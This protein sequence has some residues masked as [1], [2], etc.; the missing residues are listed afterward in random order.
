MNNR[1][2]LAEESTL[3]GLLLDQKDHDEV[4]EILK[5]EDFSIPENRALY[6]EITDLSKKN[7]L[8]DVI[9]V[10]EKRGISL[11]R[12]ANLVIN[13]P[14]AANVITYATFVKKASNK[15]S[16][17]KQLELAQRQLLQDPDKSA[18]EIIE[19]FSLAV[20]P[21]AKPIN[22]NI[23]PFI[24]VQDMKIKTTQW[25]IDSFLEK[26]S[27]VSIFGPPEGCKSLV[28]MD[29]GLCI[30]TGK[31]WNKFKTSQGTVFFIAGEGTNGLSK[32]KEAWVKGNDCS[33]DQL[34]N[35][36]FLSK[37]AADFCSKESV[38]NVA[39]SIENTCK[40][41]GTPP[42]LIII[43]TLARNFGSGNEN[44]TEDM[45]KF[46]EHI[47]TYL[48]KP[49]KTTVLII[50][51]SGHGSHDRGRGSSALKAGMDT[52]YKVTKKD[53]LVSMKC[54]KMKDASYPKPMSFD[55]EV[56]NLDILNEDGTP[57]NS[58]VLTQTDYVPVAK[59]IK[60]S[61][62]NQITLLS[63]LKTIFSEHREEMIRRGKSADEAK[64]TRKYWKDSTSVEAKRFNESS[65]SL[66]KMGLVSID[67]GFVS[68]TESSD[69]I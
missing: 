41:S 17:A 67:G 12:V 39:Q 34:L 35:N 43:D 21:I 19:N 33:N 15:R 47:D 40:E 51:H 65:D 27:L 36:F 56:I 53:T 4:F 66:I 57:M 28:A 22:K 9:T 20:K 50:H 45:N 24:S 16:L 23:F 32:R 44:S 7:M 63:E 59:Q 14:S 26:D 6:K 1:T 42:A 30:A 25:L 58:V 62:K 38:I 3:G 10:S 5:P 13:T 68:L 69:S 37:G 48:R 55:I 64:V 8:C 2:L 61:G 60:P 49:F 54:T 46:I 18:D 11:P 29:M 52:E 31:E